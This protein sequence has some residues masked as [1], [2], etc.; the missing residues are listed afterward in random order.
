M[1]GWN[2][3]RGGTLSGWLACQAIFDELEQDFNAV[4]VRG[5]LTEV[6]QFLVGQ[7]ELA[8]FVEPGSQAV[9]AGDIVVSQEGTV[10]GVLLRNVG[11]IFDPADLLGGNKQGDTGD[12]QFD[13]LGVFPAQLALEHS[14][15]GAFQTDL[16]SWALSQT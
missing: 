11:Q 10:L 4:V 1:I 15:V 16:R 13:A 6:Q 12:E 5:A 7:R 14:A 8:I 2:V 9:S 3:R